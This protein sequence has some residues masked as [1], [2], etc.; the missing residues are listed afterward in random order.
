M[1]LKLVL[2]KTLICLFLFSFL[3]FETMAIPHK[4]SSEEIRE[5]NNLNDH[6]PTSTIDLESKSNRKIKKQK[7]KKIG[8]VKRLAI[9]VFSKKLKKDKPRVFPKAIWSFIL[10]L[11]SLIPV[12][13]VLLTIGTFRLGTFSLEKIKESKN[14]W[15]GKFFAVAGITLAIIS[16]LFHLIFLIFALTNL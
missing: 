12:I 2:P 10:G 15:R 7:K 14:E 5:F 11:L 9:K 3:T 13:G 8:W 16:I 1:I 4:V 6:H